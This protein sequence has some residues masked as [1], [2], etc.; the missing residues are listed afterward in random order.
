MTTVNA[1]MPIWIEGSLY[2]KICALTC[3]LAKE[4]Q[5]FLGPGLY[6]GIFAMYLQCQSKKSGTAIIL[7]YAVCLLY[8][9]STS[10]FV[11]DLV[12]YIVDVSNNSI[13]K[14]TFFASLLCRR[15]THNQ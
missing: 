9:L 12:A 7:F 8:I 13:F 11:S 3:T 5:L 15:E 4:V 2:G 6:S 10:T 14:N 1:F